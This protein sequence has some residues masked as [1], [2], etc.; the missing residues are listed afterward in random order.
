MPY[1]RGGSLNARL[2]REDKFSLEQ[3]DSCVR[4]ASAALDYAH[5]HGIIH[6][7]IKPQNML[8]R[9]EDDRLLLA[10]FGIAKLLG[11]STSATSRSA[12]IGTLAYMAP[13]QFR[14]EVTPA[15][16]IYALGCVLFELLSGE[17]PFLGTTE[18]IVY[19][20]MLAPIPSIVERSNGMASE[21]LQSVIERVL[22]KQPGDRFS[23]AGDLARSFSAAIAGQAEGRVP[24]VVPMPI[25]DSHLRQQERPTITAYAEA[26]H[27]QPTQHDL[28]ALL[29]R[30]LPATQHYDASTSVTQGAATAESDS[31][32]RRIGSS[33]LASIAVVIVIAGVI[34]FVVISMNTNRRAAIPV[35]AV[36]PSATAVAIAVVPPIATVMPNFIPTSTNI[37]LTATLVVSSLPTVT[38]V[39]APTPTLAAVPTATAPAVVLTTPSGARQ[40]PA[41]TTGMAYRDSRGRFSFVVPST[42][43]QVQA[44]GAEVAFQS[45][46]TPGTIPATVNM[47]VETLPSANVTLDEYDRAG[48]ANLRQ[49]FPD[50]KSI[51]LERV[52]VAGRQA[53]VRTYT[54]TIS[55]RIL[56]LQ[57]V[58]LV[59]GTYAYVLS[60]GAP[61]IDFARYATLLE[62]ISGSL[63]IPAR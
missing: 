4:Q 52:M 35:N 11:S 20:H 10:D 41:L 55:G 56:Q 23:G 44:A 32:G 51:R 19:S 25:V 2:H 8:I 39:V 18:Q 37:P 1:I 33:L 53:Y 57:Q 6:R 49:Q 46:T 17:A 43:T 34:L 62:Q 63:N 45:P 21:R 14:G 59:E 27:A 16:D 5:S 7:D 3:V 47:V 60:S 48:E 42:W 30:R 58:Y 50:Y 31:N 12:A 36:T 38:V 13:E 40:L 29:Y 61:Q 28:Q 9:V 15:V 22:A 26:P 54:A 24:S